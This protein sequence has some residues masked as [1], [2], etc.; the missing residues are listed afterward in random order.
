MNQPNY[1]NKSPHRKVFDNYEI[2]PC[3]KY[4]H[5]D[6]TS[7]IEPCDETDAE[8]WTLYGHIGGEGVTAIGDF[9]SR[10]A[11]EST[12]YRI[13]GQQFTASYEANAHLQLMYA[14]EELAVALDF[15]L[16]QTVDMD[17]K[18]GIALT[19][20]EEDAQNRALDALNRA[21]GSASSHPLRSK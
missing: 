9:D 18:H 12:F 6:G 16:E 11:A 3:K 2:S 15:L 4:H 20:G 8:Y 19:E 13:T 17:L 10:D 1:L 21:R 7:H 5:T 14:A